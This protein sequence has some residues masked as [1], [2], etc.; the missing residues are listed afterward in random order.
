M[1]DPERIGKVFAPIKTPTIRTPAG[2]DRGAPL[3]FSAPSWREDLMGQRI[4]WW[5]GLLPLLALWLGV[6]TFARA[7]VEGDLARRANAALERIIG[8]PGLAIVAGRDVSVNGQIF[9]ESTRAEAL[10]AVAALPGVRKVNDGLSLPPTANPWLWRAVLE[11]GVLTI[12]GATPSPRERAA[13]AAA[14]QK[15]LPQATRVVDQS[16]FFSGAPGDFVVKAEGAL[17]VLAHLSVGEAQ[18]RG[19]KLSVSGETATPADYQAAVALAQ[20]ADAVII[21]VAAPKALSSVKAPPPGVVTPYML[22]AEKS[23]KALTLTGFYPDDAAH[24][25]IRAVAQDKFAGLAVTDKLLQGAG[26]PKGLLAASLAG[27]EQLARLRAG[28]FALLDGA[29]SLDG[30]AVTAEVADEVKSAFLAAV[31]AGF[32]VKTQL[33]GAA[34]EAPPAP[35]EAPPAPKTVAIDPHVD[36]ARTCRD[37]LRVLLLA[38]PIRFEYARAEI[39]PDSLAAL[40]SVAAIARRC[41]AVAFEVAGHWRNAHLALGRAENVVNWLVRAGIDRARLTATAADE[42]GPD[43][44]PEA[45]ETNRHIEFKLGK[46]AQ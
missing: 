15:T 42:S 6:N 39:S 21:D 27:L 9:D 14:A 46:G 45:L 24:E 20:R 40:E 12:S 18:L 44:P 37:Q 26:A 43:D 33:T 17:Q 25:K 10:A 28:Q 11:G 19:D 34:R 41:P 30:E 13:V 8:E 2:A 7:P 4:K 32:A 38:T 31:P 3:F 5:I 1:P 22:G 35:K 36:A 16:S 29:V 23:E